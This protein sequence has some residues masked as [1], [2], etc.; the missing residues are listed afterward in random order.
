LEDKPKVKPDTACQ[1]LLVKMA[2]LERVFG[3]TLREIR[4][5]KEMSQEALAFEAELTRNYISQL[6]LGE[7][8]PSLRSL[9]KLCA[10]LNTPP[11]VLCKRLEAKLDS[12]SSV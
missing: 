5:S 10:A 3:V 8:S 7:K 11:S 2:N 4:L 6:E 12:T 1:L 9:F